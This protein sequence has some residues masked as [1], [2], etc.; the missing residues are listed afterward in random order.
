M[1]APVGMFLMILGA[2]ALYGLLALVNAVW[3]NP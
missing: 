1:S 2:T 3:V